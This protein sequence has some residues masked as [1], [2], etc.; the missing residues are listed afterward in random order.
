MHRI[1]LWNLQLEPHSVSKLKL[2]LAWTWPDLEWTRAACWALSHLSQIQ[3][4]IIFAR[5]VMWRANVIW[6]ESLMKQHNQAEDHQQQPSNWSSARG[7]V[8]SVRA[9]G[10]A[11]EREREKLLNINYVAHRF[12]FRLP[13]CIINCIRDKRRVIAIEI[14]NSETRS[15]PALIAICTSHSHS[16]RCECSA[17]ISLNFSSSIWAAQIH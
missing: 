12:G 6:L 9:P 8:F 15:F 2:E 11:R 4:I 14:I 10:R 7:W 17:R 3:W 5:C 1:V 16:R 13:F